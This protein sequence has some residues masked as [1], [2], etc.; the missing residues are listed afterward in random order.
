MN[1]IRDLDILQVLALYIQLKNIE[2]DQN[3]NNYI[4]SV[5]ETINTQIA[6]LHQENDYI[7][8]QNAEIL[9]KLDN[10]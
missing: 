3:Q 8:K 10:L 5:I 7:M 1:N 9:H 6:K 2:Q 4:H